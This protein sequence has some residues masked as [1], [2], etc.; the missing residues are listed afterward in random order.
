VNLVLKTVINVLMASL[1]LFV[2]LLGQLTKILILVGVLQEDF[3]TME[4]V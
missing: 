2:N 1:A 3:C 4:I